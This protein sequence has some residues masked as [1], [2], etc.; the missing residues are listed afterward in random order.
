MIKKG[1]VK[2]TRIF[3]ELRKLKAND[4]NFDLSEKQETSS[5]NI[6]LKD[7]NKNSNS[8]EGRGGG[9]G[10]G[11]GGGKIKREHWFEI[12][13]YII[14]HKIRKLFLIFM[15]FQNGM[16]TLLWNTSK[17]FKNMRQS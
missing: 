8:V 17:D 3:I 16:G 15:I 12:S 6:I 13:K 11:G 14:K 4:Q 7:S 2:E 9:T 1:L 5:S 10:G